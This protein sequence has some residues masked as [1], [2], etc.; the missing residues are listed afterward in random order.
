V[1][2]FCYRWWLVLQHKT[3]SKDVD[4]SNTSTNVDVSNTSTNVGYIQGYHRPRTK[5]N[6]GWG[7]FDLFPKKT[8]FLFVQ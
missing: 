4:V 6:D 5:N 8:I 3:T 7:K 2:F 1:I